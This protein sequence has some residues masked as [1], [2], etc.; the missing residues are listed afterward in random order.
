VGSLIWYFVTVRPSNDLQLIGTV[1]ANEVVV[2][3][4]I[5]GRI[6]KLQIDPQTFTLGFASVATSASR[7]TA[8]TLGLN[9]Y[10]NKFVKFAADYEE[11][12]FEGGNSTGGSR[13]IERVFDTR[14][15]VAF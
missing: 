9:W 15:Q 12:W 6:Q 3:S 13:P 8:Y 10:L 1:D 11:T 4:R 2:S 14:W 5:A 7:A